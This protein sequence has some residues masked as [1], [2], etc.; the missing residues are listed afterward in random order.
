M[1]EDIFFEL[2][3]K[4]S[5]FTDKIY[6]DYERESVL[7]EARKDYLDELMKILRG[8]YLELDIVFVKEIIPDICTV[9]AAVPQIIDIYND[10]NDDDGGYTD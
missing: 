6:L 10:V 3:D 7:L 5:E 4:L 1:N 2:K 8:S 9:V